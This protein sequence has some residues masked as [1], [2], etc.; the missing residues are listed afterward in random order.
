MATVL[1]VEAS[2]AEHRIDVPTGENL[3]RAALN[4][5]LDGM[6]GE[7]GGGLAC[8]TCHCYVEEDWADRLPAPAQTELDMLECT[9]S[10]RRPSSRLG[11]QIIASDALDGLVVH[12]PAAQY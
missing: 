12:L 4:E 2:G 11:C 10:E 6:V 5:G 3:M 1:F 9:A 8:A 7:C